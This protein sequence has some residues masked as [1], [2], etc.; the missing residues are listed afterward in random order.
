[1]RRDGL[2]RPVLVALVVAMSLVACS[3]PADD[4]SGPGSSAATRGGIPTQTPDVTPRER[5]TGHGSGKDDGEKSVLVVAGPTLESDFPEYWGN[6]YPTDDTRCSNFSHHLGSD[7]TVVS[8]TVSEPLE[9][10]GP[11][12]RGEDEEP[13]PPC[14]AGVVLAADDACGVTLRFADPGDRDRDFPE[15]LQTWVLAT[16]CTGTQDE[17][18]SDPAVVAAGPSVS[19]PV[20]VRWT[21]TDRL[22]YC[23]ATDYADDEGFAGGQGTRPSNGCSDVSRAESTA[24]ST[25]DT[26]APTADP[27]A[28]PG[29]GG[30]G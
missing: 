28:S 15:I 5:G 27:T 25:P 7:V 4:P 29:D 17:P 9:L 12:L 6:Y 19:H 24:P 23:G 21:A 11:C 2:V 22:R 20:P 3:S 1:M 10:A 16:V 26:T 18:C 13:A 14:G 30:G 8:V